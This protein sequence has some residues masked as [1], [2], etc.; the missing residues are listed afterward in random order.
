MKLKMCKLKHIFQLKFS[1]LVTA[2]FS[3]K[4]LLIVYHID[5]LI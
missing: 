1:E 3:M 2:E 4:Y 5:K